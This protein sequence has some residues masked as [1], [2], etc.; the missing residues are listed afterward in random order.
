[1][2]ELNSKLQRVQDARLKL[3]T[4]LRDKGMEIEELETKRDKLDRAEERMQRKRI[5]EETLWRKIRSFIPGQ[6]AKIQQQR[7]RQD[8]MINNIIKKQQSKD[9]ETDTKANEVATMEQAS[10]KLVSLEIKIKSEMRAVEG[11][12]C[13]KLSMWKIKQM[14]AQNKQA[15]NMR[16]E[17][18]G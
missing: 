9:L 5:A 12:W 18:R 7:R 6:K 14:W 3:K 13:M 15:R 4:I 11:E 1:M 8:S 17:P 10:G 2:E 16:T